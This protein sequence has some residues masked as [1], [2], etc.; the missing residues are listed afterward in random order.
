MAEELTAR[1]DVLAKADSAWLHW[2][3][4]LDREAE[5]GR[6]ELRGTDG[7]TLAEAAAHVANWHA[8]TT[9][10]IDRLLRKEHLEKLDIDGQNQE[11]AAADKGISFEAA[12]ERLERNWR[13]FRQM[14]EEIP[15]ARWNRLAPSI[16]ANTWEHYDEHLA[17]RPAVGQGP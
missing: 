4:F 6:A 7:W 1:Q 3:R 14:A 15:E 9:D 17:W 2:R 13:R 12:V 11:W 10:R 8:L 5:G 16:R